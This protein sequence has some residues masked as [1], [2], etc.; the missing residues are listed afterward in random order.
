MASKQICFVAPDGFTIICLDEETIPAVVDK[1]VAPVEEEVYSLTDGVRY[2]PYRYLDFGG[3]PDGGICTAT[4][5]TQ[6]RPATGPPSVGERVG[7]AA[8][9]GAIAGFDDCPVTPA[10][11]ASPAATERQ[12]YAIRYWQEVPVPSPQP[13]I[14]P[15]RAITGLLAY[16]ETRGS[17]TNTYTE[18]DT[19][20][21][22]LTVTATGRYY[23]DWGDGTHT[24]P[25][26]REGQPWPDG[27]ITHE[28]LHIGTYDVVVTERWTATWYFGDESG[29][30][31]ELRTVG[32]IED[33]PVQQIQ[34]VV[35]R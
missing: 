19:P 35:L 24:G 31:N 13:H 1:V 18:A 30:L 7:E 27:Q 32:R 34:A 12:A 5:F 16:L 23:V 25:Y 4:G 33:F 14:A 28:Y 6:E 29:T 2:V 20:F 22:P 9:D 15:G 21:G 10:A 8:V 17:T 11:E 3:G 26:S